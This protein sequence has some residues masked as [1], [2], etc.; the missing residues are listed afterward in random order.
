VEDDIAISRPIRAEGDPSGL[1]VSLQRGQRD[2]A[3]PGVDDAHTRRASHADLDVELVPHFQ[4]PRR[5]AGV[6]PLEYDYIRGRQFREPGCDECDDL[7]RPAAALIDYGPV[8][9][10]QQ[11]PGAG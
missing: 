1:R 7:G 5:A 11:R 4:E 10:L 3:R 6:I 8:V 2:A 9:A